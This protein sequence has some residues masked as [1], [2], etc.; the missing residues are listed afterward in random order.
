MLM[1]GSPHA[2][3]PT[4]PA[5][6]FRSA[7]D[8]VTVGVSVRRGN[9]PVTG[10]TL[11]HFSI[12]DNGVP[13]RVS[14]ISYEKM[15]IHLT[16]LFDVSMSVSGPILDQ[17][18]RSVPDL[19]RSLR[20]GDHLNVVTFNQQIR[21][22]LAGAVATDALTTAFRT[23]SAAGSSAVFD[24]LAVAMTVPTPADRRPLVIL[25]SDGEDSSSITSAAT[26][27][28]VARRTT[29]TVSIVL[30]TGVRTAPGV[31]YTTLADE[32][33][34]T[35]V[36]L[37]PTGRLGDTLAGAIDRFRTSYVL[38]YTPTGV[39][40]GGA[41]AIDVR[42]SQPGVEIRARKSYLVR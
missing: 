40:L 6:T 18:R 1:S 32:T 41:H 15:P 25:F 12:S 13:Q 19:S 38:T 7:V 28:E 39:T 23:L 37:P 10:L 16:V 11:D 26:L 14:T 24:S 2:Q 33:G 34:G 9:R 35:V 27:L 36:T 42:V 3:A 8:A 20:P 21:R 29:P 5:P 30:A 17:L 22:M 4:T 31:I